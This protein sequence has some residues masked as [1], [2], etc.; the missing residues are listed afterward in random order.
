M[1]IE[2]RL[3]RL[4]ACNRRLRLGMLALA[5]LMIAGATLAMGEVSDFFR[6]RHFIV[7]DSSN[8]RRAEFFMWSDGSVEYPGI[9]FLGE[10]GTQKDRDRR[11]FVGLDRRGLPLLQ[12]YNEKGDP[13]YYLNITGKHEGSA[14]G[15][16]GAGAEV[17]AGDA[18][19]VLWPDDRKE[20]DK[21]VYVNDSGEDAV[22]HCWG[23][24]RLD[25]KFYRSMKLC[26]AKEKGKVPCKGCFSEMY[27]E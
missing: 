18:G 24:P 1:D 13:C 20:L 21:V 5:L 2:K 4:E 23:C 10:K 27:R 22:F 15:E 17:A 9:W 7:Q 11:L 26:Q 16:D 19:D 25:R 14:D 12:F 3:A 8:T 6:A